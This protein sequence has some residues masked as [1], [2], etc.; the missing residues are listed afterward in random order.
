MS[1]TLR[2]ETN[3]GAMPAAA[4]IAVA[5]EDNVEDCSVLDEKRES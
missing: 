4:D 2:I 3:D 5:K 1:R